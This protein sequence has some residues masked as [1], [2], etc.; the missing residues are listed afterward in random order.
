MCSTPF[1]PKPHPTHFSVDQALAVI[2]RLRPKR[3]Y[4]THISHSLDHV[5]TEKRLPEGVALAYDGLV[6]GF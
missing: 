3:A 1:A 5:E 4:L 2:K 6:L